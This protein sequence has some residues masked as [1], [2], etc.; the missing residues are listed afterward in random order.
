V[1]LVAMRLL[2]TTLMYDCTVCRV[3]EPCLVRGRVAACAWLW[4]VR[5]CT[6]PNRMHLLRCG[7][8]PVRNDAARV[9]GAYFYRVGGLHVLVLFI[10]KLVEPRFG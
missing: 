1:L 7:L 10:Y 5:G 2:A 8:G 4:Q 3:A 9:R 6:K